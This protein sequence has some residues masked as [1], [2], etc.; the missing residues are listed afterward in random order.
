MHCNS[1]ILLI[2]TFYLQTLAP[3]VAQNPYYPE[4]QYD[5]ADK[6]PNPRQ[7]VASYPHKSCVKKNHCLP[8]E[9]KPRLRETKYVM[10]MANLS[11]NPDLVEPESNTVFIISKNSNCSV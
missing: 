4:H 3:C 8:T 7:S 2:T 11:Y 5:F 9:E 6:A 10:R 1:N